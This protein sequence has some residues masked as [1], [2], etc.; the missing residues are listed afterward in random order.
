MDCV[1]EI[2]Q[3]AKAMLALK[4]E[5]FWTY[6]SKVVQQPL[7]STWVNFFGAQNM[8]FQRGNRTT[9]VLILSLV[10]LLLLPLVEED[11]TPYSVLGVTVTSSREEIFQ[12]Y[13]QALCGIRR[14]KVS[15]MLVNLLFT[16]VS[17]IHNSYQV[18]TDPLQRC[19]YH[20]FTGMADWYGVPE[21][22]SLE[23]FI[24]DIKRE[25]VLQVWDA[26]FNS[27]SLWGHVRSFSESTLPP[28]VY[29]LAAHIGVNLQK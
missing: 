20:R 2:P 9:R 28:A 17:R 29:N 19:M 1:V 4:P 5:S 27:S 16:R 18:L 7:W 8:Q 21:S 10:I 15:S 11:T 6:I 25:K 24:E 26:F 23:T 14:S 3:F 22:C 13:T 12:A